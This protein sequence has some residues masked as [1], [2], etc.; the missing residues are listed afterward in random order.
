[1]HC[2]SSK[3]CLQKYTSSVDNS[4]YQQQSVSE[5]RNS[6]FSKSDV[7]LGSANTVSVLMIL[8]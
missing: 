1:M 6:S 5:L 4:G 2:P 7:T 3:L 8:S